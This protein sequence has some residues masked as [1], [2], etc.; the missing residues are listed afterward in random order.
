MPDSAPALTVTLL[1]TGTSTGV[2]VIGCD[3]PVCSSDAP[4]DARLRASSLLDLPP[5]A[6]PFVVASRTHPDARVEVTP[7]RAPHGTFEVLGFRI[8]DFGYL[9]DV[10]EVPDAARQALDGIDTLVLDGLRPDP[11][12]THLTFDEAA[13]VALEMGVRETWLTHVTHAMGHDEA[14]ATLPAGVQLAYD[15]LVLT[16]GGAA[17]GLRSRAQP[18]GNLSNTA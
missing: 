1:G 6:G 2:P 15:G 13:T 18:G 9:T 7:V 16:M 11:H 5:V 10:G 17:G 4:R 14:N 8:G 12:P 3:C